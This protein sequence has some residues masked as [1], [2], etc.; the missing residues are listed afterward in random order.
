RCRQQTG[1]HEDLV[2]DVLTAHVHG[3]DERAHTDADGEE[4]EQRLGEAGEEDHPH[5]AVGE[6][7]ALD[8]MDE[9]RGHCDSFLVNERV[10]ERQPAITHAASTATCTTAG[11]KS[12]DPVVAPR[13]SSTPCHN[14][15]STHNGWS[16]SGSW[17]IGKNVP[18]NRN[19]G[20]IPIRMISGKRAAAAGAAGTGG[21]G[22]ATAAAHKGPGG[23]AN[24][25][26]GES[27]ARRRAATTI[28]IAA[29][30]RARR[31]A[32]ITPPP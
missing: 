10:P 29:R 7:V 5:A 23:T 27:P 15:D 20:K 16:A 1:R 30:R 17:E 12:I 26:G 6:H 11:Q 3:T 4:I 13:H 18:E 9:E 21:G 28:K 22:G 14:G 32:Q 25:P 8:D 19:S 31:A 2:V 24:T